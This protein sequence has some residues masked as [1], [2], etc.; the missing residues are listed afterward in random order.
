V[1]NI[2]CPLV[3]GL[4]V[5]S[6]LTIQNRTIVY[7]ERKVLAYEVEMNMKVQSINELRDSQGLRI[8]LVAGAPSPWGQAAKAMMEYKGLDY[9]AGLMMAGAANEEVVNWA[10]VNSG[11]I[12]A[13]NDERPIDRWTDILFLIERL[14]PEPALIPEKAQ[15]R[16]D[17]FGLSHELNGE[18][19][20][21][22]NRR[23]LMFAPV[24]ESGD[25]PEAIANM[26]AKY[27]YNKHDC[28][29]ATDRIISVLGLLDERLEAQKARGS[30]Y[31]IGNNPTALDFY[32]T[33]F[34]ILIDL[35]PFDKIPLA[36]E[37]QP[38]FTQNDPAIKS[39]FT[40]SLCEHRDRFFDQY[41]KSPMEF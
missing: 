24:V 38:L 5:Y 28:D 4:V 27:K 6:T 32:W 22:W 26:S 9:A 10:G 20:M 33:A 39:A 13:W 35:M 19:G 2:L 12:V 15:D 29:R 14:A 17:L 11:P 30:S 7:S 31:F 34:S 18:L 25:A 8:V 40:P 3:C 21:G 41:F 23:L 37:L 1:R 36:K 16:A